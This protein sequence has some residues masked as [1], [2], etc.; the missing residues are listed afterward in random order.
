MYPLKGAKSEETET[1]FTAILLFAGNEMSNGK[2]EKIGMLSSAL[3]Q[4]KIGD[5]SASTLLFELCEA[6]C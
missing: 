3:I 1:V 6:T 2:H 5:F 4:K